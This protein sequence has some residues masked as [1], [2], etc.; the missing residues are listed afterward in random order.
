MESFFP[1]TFRMDFAAE[2]EKFTE[3]FDGK[4]IIV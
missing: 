2:R 3:V 4:R 1:Q